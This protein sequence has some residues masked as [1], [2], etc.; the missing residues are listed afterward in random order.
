MLELELEL[1][2]LLVDELVELVDELVELVDELELLVV[3]V[4][5]VVPPTA[6]LQ[7]DPS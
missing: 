1:D 5:V 2:V 4:E 7:A 3:E 6:D